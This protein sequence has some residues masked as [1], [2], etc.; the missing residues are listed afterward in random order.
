M[1][2][3]IYTC[4]LYITKWGVK[5][6]DR[7]KS[8]FI[9]FFTTNKKRKY[10]KKDLNYWSDVKTYRRYMKYCKKL[11]TVNRLEIELAQRSRNTYND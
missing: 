10:T 3:C 6:I 7:I 4:K 9:S 8:C 1:T 5:M 11:E 2:K